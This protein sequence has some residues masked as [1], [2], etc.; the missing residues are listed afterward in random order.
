EAIGHLRRALAVIAAIVDES[1]RIKV[2][3]E[4]LIGLGAAFMAAHGFGAPEVLEPYAR[5]EALCERLGERADIFPALWGQWLFRWGRTELD[6][7]W[8]LAE[9]LGALAEDTR[10]PRRHAHVD[11]AA[12]RPALR[13]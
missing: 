3:V 9:R 13:T 4:L 11:P 1:E 8:R 6:I 12:A 10:D 7:A 5:A 2:E